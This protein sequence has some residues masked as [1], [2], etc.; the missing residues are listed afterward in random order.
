MLVSAVQLQILFHY[1]LLQDIEYSSICYA[2]NPCCIS[3]LHIV[4]GVIGLFLEQ[5]SI[6]EK[7]KKTVKKSYHTLHTQFP[8]LLTSY[9]ST[10]HLLL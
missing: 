6:Y 1:R 2:A 10:A 3:I 5:F 8:L 4:V 9:V 7:V